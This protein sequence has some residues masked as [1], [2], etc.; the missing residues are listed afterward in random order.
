MTGTCLDSEW[1]MGSVEDRDSVVRMVDRIGSERL[2]V[3]R[4][5]RPFSQAGLCMTIAPDIRR[6]CAEFVRIGG[7]ETVNA[8]S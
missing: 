7:H 5:H 6:H 8:G 4:E 1:S 2:K 3:R